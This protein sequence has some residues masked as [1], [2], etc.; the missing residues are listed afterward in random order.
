MNEAPA[1]VCIKKALRSLCTGY[2]AR[3]H[4]AI[5]RIAVLVCKTGCIPAGFIVNDGLIT[6][7]RHGQE[8][9]CFRMVRYISFN[10]YITS[11][12]FAGHIT[13]PRGIRVV[14]F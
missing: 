12:R 5:T 6:R 1:G 14:G 4:G 7:N 11:D 2:I 13:Q 8:L 9:P 10:C 3:D